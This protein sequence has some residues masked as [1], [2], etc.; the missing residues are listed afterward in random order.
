V[1]AALA[2]AAEVV[3]SYLHRFPIE[4][5]LVLVVPTA[6]DDLH[7]RTL[8]GGGATLM[9][10]VGADSDGATLAR[11]WVPAHELMHLAFPTL[12]RDQLWI[13]EGEATYVEPIARVRAGDLSTEK[14]WRDLVD[15]LPQ[16]LPGSGDR[17]LDRT[18]TWGRTYWGGALFWLLADVEIRQKTGNQKS[19]DDA[20]RA[21]IAEGGDGSETWP[22]TKIFHRGDAA[23]GMPILEKLHERLGTR[24]E[25][26]DLDALWQQLGVSRRGSA[27]VFN[28]DAPLAGI[29]R[30]LTSGSTA[31]K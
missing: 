7:W 20:L 8:G 30:A 19:L 17:G 26:T 23:I 12:S 21:I 13:A 1:L 6:G 18:H 15:G 28:D 27:V 24:P 14:V 9:L 2:R 22:A 10:Y 29:R 4:R 31:P 11:S 5:L 3:R 16:G 25:V